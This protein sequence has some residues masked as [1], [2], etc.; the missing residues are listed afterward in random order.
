MS[1][2]LAA[3]I[4]TVRIPPR[5]D[6]NT[7]PA[8]EQTLELAGVRELILDFDACEYV[9]SAGIR[10]I[11]KAFQRLSR[12]GGAMVVKNVAGEVYGI[13]DISGLAQMI[14]LER[15]LREISLD[16]LEPLSAGVCGECFRLDEET[17]V[18][19]YREGVD[20]S[21][22]AQEKRHARA[23][24]VMGIPTA[25]SYELVVC[26]TRT[27]VVFEMLEAELF[28]SVIRNDVANLDLHARTL[29]EVMKRLHAA[30]GDPAVLPD[31]KARFRG[32]IEQIG[33]YLSDQESR[34]LLE[35][36][37]AIPEADTCV[38]FDLHS[39]NIMIRE[40]EPVIIDMGDLSIGSYLFDVGLMYT[41]Y[42]IPEF[43]FSE[44]AT[45]ISADTGLEFWRCFERH[46]FEDR[47]AE[48][49]AFFD[50][51]RY[52]LASLRV[53]YTITFLPQV[54]ENFVRILKESL[55]PRMM[56]SQP[57]ASGDCPAARRLHAHPRPAPE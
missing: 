18:K 19:L 45:Q 6:V 9:S 48:E 38:H 28:S 23:A 56:D 10:M 20:P 27:G 43:G 44:L 37:E 49:Y 57:P 21:I 51:N 24:F 5:L 8:L 4:L 40:G 32:Y 54:R 3:S 42:G 12:V 26:G 22:A 39:S 50:E 36:L 15:K 34:F 29:A 55:L 11:L 31:M 53:I 30:K 41:I 2:D 16:G 14:P 47:S 35:R 25:I 7:A 1:G 17:V 33:G 52:F 13:F 46:F